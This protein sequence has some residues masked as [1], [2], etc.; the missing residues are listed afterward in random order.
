ML[1][2]LEKRHIIRS[3]LFPLILIGLL[4]T[5]ESLEYYSGGDFHALGVF[6]RTLKGLPGIISAPFIHGS[7]QH[8]IANSTP[9]LF[10]TMGLIYFYRPI[11]LKVW[12][13][14]HLITGFWVWAA[15]RQVWHIGISGL[16]YGLAFFLFFSGVFRKD[17]R[18]IAIS[19]IVAFF[20]GSMVWGILP[21]KEGMSWE[22]HLFGAIAGILTAFHYRKRQL[23]FR[24]KSYTWEDQPDWPDHDLWDYQK[25]F[26]PPDGYKYPDP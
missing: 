21:V 18:A 8:L 14:I 10:L 3:I 1:K 16:V 6:P 11:A 2:G 9:L 17:I 24:K 20:Y 25:Q 22:S 26:P 13:A 12:L 19:L 23:P 7:W 5:V 4:W 15:A